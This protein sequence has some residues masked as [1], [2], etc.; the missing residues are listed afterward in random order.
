MDMMTAPLTDE[1]RLPR[2]TMEARAAMTFRATTRIA[3][4]DRE[5]MLQ[6]DVVGRKSPREL[7]ENFG[8]R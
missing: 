3:D 6:T 1:G 4:S 5:Q 7:P 8:L 2:Q